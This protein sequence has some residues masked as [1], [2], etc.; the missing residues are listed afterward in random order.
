MSKCATSGNKPKKRRP[1]ASKDSNTFRLGLDAGEKVLRHRKAQ[2]EYYARNPDVRARRREKAAEARAAEKLKKRRWD[3][4]KMNCLPVVATARSDTPARDSVHTAIQITV[5]E[6]SDGDHFEFKDPRAH[7]NSGMVDV[8]TGFDPAA[9]SDLDAAVGTAASPT[10]EELQASHALAQLAQGVAAHVLQ[11]AEIE[12]G[13]AEV[14]VNENAID[15]WR[16]GSV[17]SILEKANLLSSHESDAAN[18][19][20]YTAARITASGCNVHR[21]DLPPGVAPLSTVQL[22]SFQITGD[23]G[24]LT[25]VQAVQ[26]SILKMNSGNLTPTTSE[27]AV[28]WHR[29]AALIIDQWPRSEWTK[30][31]LA[32]SFWRQTV[33]DAVEKSARKAAREEAR[34]FAEDGK[35]G[36][37]FQRTMRDSRMVVRLEH[38]EINAAGG[39]F[40]GDEY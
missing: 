12:P 17:D 38:D 37:W 13:Y 8:S 27:D 35:L 24:P 6:A 18:A 2:S 32:M 5:S 36:A 20:A 28:K 22:A 19:I 40:E 39:V 14:R 29:P 3:P 31:E 25:R 7:S 21:G 4:P 1:R 9:A 16:A 34:Q 15:D 10:S 33:H 23:I 11:N 30:K 26:L